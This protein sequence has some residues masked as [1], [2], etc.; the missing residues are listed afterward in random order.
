MEQVKKPAKVR[1]TSGIFCV[2]ESDGSMYS[3]LD[4]VRYASMAKGWV[5]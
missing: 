1:D 3:N 2:K 4:A 5:N